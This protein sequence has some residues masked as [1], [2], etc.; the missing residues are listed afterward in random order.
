LA[1]KQTECKHQ[2]R[3]GRSDAP[4]LRESAHTSKP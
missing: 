1:P 4:G 2:R 3:S